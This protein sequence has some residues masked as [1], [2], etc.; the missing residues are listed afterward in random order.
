MAPLVLPS[1]RTTAASPTRSTHPSSSV[2]RN[3]RVLSASSPISR[4]ASPSTSSR[5]SQAAGPA[6]PS[7]RAGP[8][9]APIPPIDIEACKALTAHTEA[10]LS[11]QNITQLNALRDELQRVAVQASNHLTGLLERKEM[12]Q[13]QNDTYNAMIQDLVLAAQ[14]LKSSS[15]P[16]ASRNGSVK[17]QS[18]TPKQGASVASLGHG[19]R[20]SSPANAGPGGKSALSRSTAGQ[21]AGGAVGGAKEQVR[22][23]SLW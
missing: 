7:S 3:G 14:K 2:A 8:Q 6:R 16:G 18:S 4:S 12:L 15:S 5:R 11:M 17:R 10:E 22:R 9:P 23:T 20:P 21:A 19:S 13:G 1:I